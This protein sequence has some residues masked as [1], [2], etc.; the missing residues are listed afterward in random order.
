MNEE[1]QVTQE[2]ATEPTSDVQSN[3]PTTE[4][5]ADPVATERP[6]WLN[7]KFETGEDLEQYCE[8]HQF[9]VAYN[10]LKRNRKGYPLYRGMELE[11]DFSHIK[12]LEDRRSAG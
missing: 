7:E 12:K 11:G 5:V 6:S 4:S 8:E 10:F 9:D 2:S 3:P 1:Q